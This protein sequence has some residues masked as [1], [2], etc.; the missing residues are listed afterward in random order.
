MCGIAGKLTFEADAPVDPAIVQRMTDALRHRGPDD[1]GVWTSGAVGLGSRRL[2][3]QDLSPR[4][5]QPMT[6]ED[7]RLCLV[8]NGEIYNFKELRAALE[9]A[10]TAFRS[11]T[12]T[13]VILHLYARHGTSCL[14]YLRGMFAFALWDGPAGRLF[15]ARDRLGKKPLYFARPGGGFSFASEVAALLQDRDIHPDVDPVGIDHYLTY[16]YVPHPRSAF[17][18]VSKLSPGHFL[19]VTADQTVD[20]E[21][22]R[23]PAITA[24]ERDDETVI[25]RIVAELEEA[26]RLRLISD[27]PVGALLSGGLDSSVV[28]ALMRRV[29]SGTIRTFSIGF[30][31]QEY[32]EL[33]YARQVAERFETEH[34]EFVVRPDAAHLLPLLA[35]HY[36]EPFADSSAI[37][38]FA[39]SELARRHVTVALNGDGGDEVFA[40]YD[41]YRAMRTAS[42]IERLPHGLRAGL[43]SMAKLA[44]R[45]HQKSLWT[46]VRR[47]GEALPLSPAERYLRWLAIF[48][49][50]QK[51]SIYVSDR[52]RAVAD[53]SAPR[54]LADAFASVEATT[55]VER[56]IGADLRLYLP[57]DLLAKMDIASMAYSLELRSPLLDHRVVEIASSI[58]AGTRMRDGRG[59][60]LLRRAFGRVLPDAVVSRRKMG[61]AVPI[62]R[63]LRVDLRDLTG[64]LL[65]SPRA[66]QRGWFEPSAIRAMLE[67]HWTGRRSWHAQ[68]WSLLMLE[69]WYRTFIDRPC[70]VRPPVAPQSVVPASA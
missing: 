55:E 17:T 1:Q 50:E 44:P 70:E 42:R 58:P 26:V 67:E 41:R 7:G 62:E 56:A 45:A 3:V 32:S 52:A 39:V 18:G 20:R 48:P 57:D 59:K 19:I 23:P 43:A 14:E 13:E 34:H 28:V 4:G 29:H 33:A 47:F 8:F 63:W 53:A 25:R 60:Y 30:E 69:T 22:W 36:G 10:G 46:K 64:D 68:I 35:W 65:L 54:V 12:D 16:G 21:Y 27:V 61:F 51:Q 37:P 49:E 66:L 6:S 31:E 2:A 5:H 24:A 15:V 40:G 11:D 9:Q 38:S